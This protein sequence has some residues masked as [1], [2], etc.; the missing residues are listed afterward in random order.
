MKYLLVYDD[1]WNGGTLIEKFNDSESLRQKYVMLNS[2]EE[3]HVS[4][5]GAISEEYKLEPVEIVTGYK[6]KAI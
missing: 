5:A 1:L 2:A 6:L 3:Y 4:F